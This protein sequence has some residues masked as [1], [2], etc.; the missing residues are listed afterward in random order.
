MLLTTKIW[1]SIL[2]KKYSNNLE[3]LTF[4]IIPKH[5]FYEGS[6]TNSY[7]NASKYENYI[8]IGTG[9]YKFAN[10]EKFKQLL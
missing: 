6:I 2:I 8:P 7:I 10:Y 5:V 9:P 3:A 1:K 4:P